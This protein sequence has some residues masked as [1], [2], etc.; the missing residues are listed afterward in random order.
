MRALLIAC[1]AVA[2][3]AMMAAQPVRADDAAVVTDIAGRTV[4]VQRPVKRILLG[5]GRLL[6]ALSLLHP[7][8][9][10]LLA[11]WPADL[12]RQDAATYARYRAK[13][14]GLDA[15]PIVGQGSPDTFSVEQALAV[16]PD[17]AIFSG[18][19]GPSPKSTEVIARLEAAGIPIVFLDFVAKPLEDTPRSLLILGQVLGREAQAQAYVDFYSAHLKRISDR[20]AQ[21]KPELPSV[22]MHAHAG[23]GD[24]CNSPGRATIGAFIDAAG[25]Q[26]IAADIL[27]QPSGQLNMEYVISKR[28]DIYVGT[29]GIHLA[30]TGGLVM[31]PGIDE[32]VSRA[33]LAR[34][35]AG[36]GLADLPAVHAGRV[37]GLW[38]L[39]NS[40]PTNF[41]AVE[42]LATWFHP[43][44]FADI[45]P[46][47]SLRELNERFLPV[48]MEGTYWV[49]LN[50]SAG[51]ADAGPR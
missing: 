18:G 36:P 19:Y 39:F 46:K 33:A 49:A 21:A 20:L 51:A 43:K 2:A 9:A 5:E 24:C 7:D 17:I 48:P 11:G 13:F 25:G 38:H 37:Y 8:P 34:I 14:P 12:I 32:S 4:T 31:G 16:H 1:V 44:L 26:N 28:P 6:L 10:S 30:N 50:Q 29:G 22:F 35:V 42:V 23:R 41:L 27:K 40:N 47:A 3:W 45:D 15:I